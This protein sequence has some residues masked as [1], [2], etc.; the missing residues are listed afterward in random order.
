MVDME[1]L[2]SLVK[3]INYQ[4]EVM[5]GI[6]ETNEKAQALSEQ[7]KEL[8]VYL[9]LV[10]EADEDAAMCQ[11][12]VK[13]L[14]KELKDGLKTASKVLASQS[15]DV[16]PAVLKAFLTKKVKDQEQ[17][18]KVIQLGSKFNVLNSKIS[19]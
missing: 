19:A 6:L 4:K 13:E 2:V 15:V 17:V 18:D 3:Q 16:K 5:Q 9:K 10:A 12:Q 8:Q 11:S 1:H 14:E 7:I